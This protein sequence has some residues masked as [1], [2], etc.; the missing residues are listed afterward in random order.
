MIEKVQRRDF[1]KMLGIAGLLAGTGGISIPMLRFVMPSIPKAHPYPITKL[2]W[3]DGSPVRVNELEVNKAYI[4]NYPFKNTPNFLI[5]LGDEK[6]N[7]IRIEVTLYTAMPPL[8]EESIVFRVKDYVK[9]SI[10]GFGSPYTVKGVGPH[11]SIVAYSAICQH[12]GCPY[13]A[14]NFYAPGRS[15]PL[16][17]SKI[18]ERGGV[19]YCVCHGGAY[20]PYRGAA[21]LL[22]PPQRPLPFV[23]LRE[24]NEELYAV[25]IVG[26][27]IFGKFCNTCGE[28]GDLVGSISVVKEA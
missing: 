7:P 17:R 1:I 21:I 27:T 25:N 18:V 28:E 3:S 4:F 8:A 22:D 12:F 23:I 20:D 26:A 10:P 11:G 9:E 2:V 14:I 6:G 19:I 24:E 16:A 13:P 15:V 5:N